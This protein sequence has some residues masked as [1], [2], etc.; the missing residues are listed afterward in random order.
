MSAP[1]LLT[2][3]AEPPVP[4][5]AEDDLDLALDVFLAQRARL[6]RIAYRVLGDVPG[7]E[8]VVQEIWLRWQLTSRARIENAAAFLTA[9]TTR[10]AINVIQSAR[11]RH[12]SPAEPRPGDLADR[13]HDPV[14]RTERA[15]AAE[16]ALALLMARLTPDELAAFVLRKG[17]D[18][19]YADL[20]VLLRTSVP[21]ARQLVRRAQ[22]RAGG[23]R[24]RPVPAEAHRRLVAAFRTAVGTGDVEGL[25]RLLAPGGHVHRQLSSAPRP[26]RPG[27]AGDPRDQS[28][29]GRQSN[30][31]FQLSWP[32]A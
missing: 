5:P 20:A 26:S 18:H 30:A 4:P 19:A 14:L 24:E 6:F 27:Q 23:G 11:H 13:T 22:S 31:V 25:A 10:L 15:M 21:N 3:P 28:I 8:D 1:S 9:A 16:D 2:A 17:F 32:S 7:A 29:S 12:E